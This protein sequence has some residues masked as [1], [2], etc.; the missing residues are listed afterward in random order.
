MQQPL[1]RLA[2]VLGLCAICLGAT[3][4]SCTFF[5][6]GRDES[7]LTI[8]LA[9]EAP[10]DPAILQVVVPLAGLEFR[11]DDDAVE[12]LTFTDT[13]PVDLLALTGTNAPLRLF[14]EESLSEGT[15]TGVRLLFDE[16][17][18]DSGFVTDAFGREFGLRIA[19]GDYAPFDFTVAEGERDEAW[20][21]TLDLRRALVFDDDRDE[22]ELRPALRSVLTEDS[23][24]IL[25]SVTAVCVGGRTLE[26]GAVY[27][28][29]NR[30]VRPD[31][32]DGLDPEPFATT[33][34]DSDPIAGTFTYALRFLPE[35][36]YTIALTCR[37]DEDLVDED[38]E[39]RFQNVRNIEIDLD[40]EG[41]LVHDIG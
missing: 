11:R 37:G 32:Y 25:G 4:E 36:R 15:Y 35:G 40:D 27:L 9:A 26:T 24:D 33:P 7:D 28:F 21:L 23:R 8:D 34:L 13:E 17:D 31:D 14:T 38:D 19:Q 10:A 5:G 41:S 1:P 16:D 39:L 3:S 20:T 29:E 2:S 18:I 30:N 6:I 22:F 12:T